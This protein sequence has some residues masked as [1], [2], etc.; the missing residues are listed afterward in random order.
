MSKRVCVPVFAVLLV[1]A[2]IPPAT[3][4]ASPEGPDLVASISGEGSVSAGNPQLGGQFG[5][6]FEN[7]GNASATGTTVLTLNLPA[8]MT[9]TGARFEATCSPISFEHGSGCESTSQ[10][11]SNGGHTLTFTFHGTV[12]AGGER[13]LTVLYMP[14]LTFSALPEGTITASV[15]NSADANPANNHVCREVGP[16]LTGQSGAQGCWVGSYGHQNYD[17]AGWDGSSDVSN[18]ASNTSSGTSL[19]VQQGSRWVWASSTEDPRALE[20]PDQSTREAATYYDANEIKLRLTFAH[21]FT[22]NVHLYAVDWDSHARRET[23]TVASHTVALSGD[24]S[25]GAWVTLPISVAAGGSVPI[26][27]DRTAGVNAVL[28]GIFLGEAGALPIV[29]SAKEVEGASAPQGSWVGTY[30]SAGYDLGAWS[31]T[32]DL[33][34]IPSA[35]VSLAQGNRWEWSSSTSDLRAL[36][37]PDKSTREAATY[38]DPNQLRL[39]LTFHAAYTGNLHL[40]ALD[41]DSAAR[42]ELISVAGQTAVLGEA[43]SQGAW[44]TFPISVAAGE[45]VP[46][47][48]DRT[49]GANAVLSGIFLG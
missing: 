36:E 17:L 13:G 23:I 41:W 35:T 24:F 30:G 42:R 5:A 28:S 19:S 9:T 44:V 43:F 3:A 4:I 37:S 14:G 6:S 40:Y 49:A 47:V 34:S 18:F 7:V 25:Q 22:G 8:S 27:V 31:G 38:Y 11:I 2:L 33:A 46:I 21:A 20:S 10:V 12:P 16:A 26:V 39:T 45:T 48:V 32:G 15:S 29:R 1:G